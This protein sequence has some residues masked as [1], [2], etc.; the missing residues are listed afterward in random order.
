M[1]HHT[2]LAVFCALA[3]LMGCGITGSGDIVTIKKNISGFDKVKIS[4]GCEADIQY[5]DSFNVEISIDD[6]LTSDLVVSESGGGLTIRMGRGNFRRFTCSAAI[7]M[8]VFTKLMAS[9]A[10][11]IELAGFHLTDPAKI[12]AEDAGSIR[13][14]LHAGNLTVDINDASSV[15]LKGSADAL[16]LYVEDASKA[17]LE[18]FPVKTAKVE[19]EDASSAV[20]DVSDTLSIRARDASSLTYYGSPIVISRSV[21]DASRIKRKE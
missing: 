10:S 15:N 13:G 12:T 20:I 7:L 5:G 8:P 6:N 3:L 4:N 19:L 16:T 21:T 9:D 2:I 17:D 1:K 14:Q 18:D 11:S